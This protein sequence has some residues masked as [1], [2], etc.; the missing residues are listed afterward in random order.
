VNLDNT[1]LSLLDKFVP[2]RMN[3]DQGIRML[4]SYHEKTK[5]SGST[6][7]V[8]INDELQRGEKS[9]NV[10]EVPI[11]ELKKALERKGKNLTWKDDIQQ[12]L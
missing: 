4:V 8:S 7:I 6:H 9:V 2:Y 12:I 5:I 10:I 1:N 3:K 11:T